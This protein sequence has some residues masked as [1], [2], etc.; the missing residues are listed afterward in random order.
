MRIYLYNYILE[1]V[2]M[3]GVMLFLLFC[4]AIFICQALWGDEWQ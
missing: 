4:Y 3:R 1:A 2:I